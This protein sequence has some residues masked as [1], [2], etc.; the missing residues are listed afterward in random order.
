MTGSSATR[1]TPTHANS[2]S[3]GSARE[4]EKDTAASTTENVVDASYDR[5]THASS[6]R[7]PDTLVNKE[8]PESASCAKVHPRSCAI[9]RYSTP[10]LLRT[11]ENTE[12]RHQGGAVRASGSPTSFRF[13]FGTHS[14]WE[15]FLS[16]WSRRGFQMVHIRHT[17][18]Q[19]S[20]IVYTRPRRRGKENARQ[21]CM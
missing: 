1:G 5:A 10:L 9:R 16:S 6:T 13:Y 12:E 7:S 18:A 3:T 8:L 15:S 19:Y 11:W 17:H 20:R 4:R 2:I 14:R 21:A